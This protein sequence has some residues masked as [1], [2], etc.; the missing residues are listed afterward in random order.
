VPVSRMWALKVTR[1]TMAATRPGSGNTCPG[2]RPRQM[3]GKVGELDAELCGCDVPRPAGGAPS[4]LCVAIGSRHDRTP[5]STPH[6]RRR[7][8]AK[9]SARPHSPYRPDGGRSVKINPAPEGNILG[10]ACRLAGFVR[11]PNAAGSCD[12]TG[13]RRSRSDRAR[14]PR[15]DRVDPDQLLTECL[16]QRRRHI[17]AGGGRRPCGRSLSRRNAARVYGR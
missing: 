2:P 17:G 16:R 13:R 1:S 4:V 11:R 12:P 5:R 7:A 8:R 9:R 15:A 6:R 3:S 14:G 10:R